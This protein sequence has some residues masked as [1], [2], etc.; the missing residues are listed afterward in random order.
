MLLSDEEVW[1]FQHSGFAQVHGALA[2]PLLGRLRAVV[3]DHVARRVAPLQLE[4]DQAE[5]APVRRLS[6]I[7]ARDPLFL[8]TASSDAIT[9][10]LSSILGSDIEL[11]TN[12]HNHLMVRPPGS[13]PVDWHRDAVVWSRPIVTVLAY[14]DDATIENGCLAVVPGSHLSPWPIHQR[15]H[16]EADAARVARLQAQAVP[17]PMR[18][19]DLLITHGCLLHGA[20]P[21]RSNG[22]RRSMTLA[23]HACDEIGDA[24]PIEKLLVRGERILRHN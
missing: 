5:P 7:I 3:E 10:P 9:E 11:C 22:P 19:G 6:K 4:P 12:R 16:V 2:E 20:G 14:L 23:Y 13:A 18:A 21:N 8:Q 24:E 1:L 17:V 15:L